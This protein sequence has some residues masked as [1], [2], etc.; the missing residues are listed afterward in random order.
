MFNS[1]SS[2]RDPVS[3]PKRWEKDLGFMIKTPYLPAQQV[4]TEGPDWLSGKEILTKYV[5]SITENKPAET[6]CYI[7]YILVL[8]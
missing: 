7:L 2:F 8:F 6:I 1:L 5:A 4:P 3:M